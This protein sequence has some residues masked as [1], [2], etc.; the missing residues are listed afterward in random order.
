MSEEVRKYWYG[1]APPAKPEER[2]DI[3]LVDLRS[4]Q[5]N[6]PPKVKGRYRYKVLKGKVVE[7]DIK[8]ITSITVHQTACTFGKNPK[9]PTR[10]HRALGVPCH[11][12]AFN[13]GVVAVPNPFLW[14]AYH[15]N[16]FNANS[17]GLEIEGSFAGAPDDPI[18]PIREDLA[19]HWGDDTKMSILTELGAATAC[20][21]IE[22]LVQAAAE[23]GGEIKTIRAHRQSSGTRRSDPGYEIWNDVVLSFAVKKLGLKTEPLLTLAKGRKIPLVW[24][25]AGKGKY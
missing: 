19:S 1:Y 3:R 9:H 8:D 23:L 7:R 24:D 18:T 5:L 6:P 20:F 16:G 4:I 2:F 10:Y 13:D 22:Y 17:A 21:A 12:L 14:F 25:P 11:A 15:G